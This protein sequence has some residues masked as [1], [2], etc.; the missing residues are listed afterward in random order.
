MAKIDLL[1]MQGEVVSS[2]ELSDAVF[3]QEWNDQIIYDVVKAQKAAMRQG[4]SQTKNRS[5]V[6]GGGR[7]PYRQKGTG[8]ARQGTIRAP[9]YRGGGHVFELHPRDYSISVN[10]KVRRQALRIALS[11]KLKDAKLIVLDSIAIEEIKTKTVEAMLK[12][13]KAEGKT[14][15]VVPEASEK[16]ELSVRNIPNAAV[17]LDSH[18]SVYDILDAKTLVITEAAAK[19][20]EEVLKNE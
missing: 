4:T 12:A 8:H 13:V 18:A 9:Q 10:K 2:L 5:D 15:I 3:A 17:S 7:K 20:Y 6:S 14:L 1:N 11:M 16:L 19:Y